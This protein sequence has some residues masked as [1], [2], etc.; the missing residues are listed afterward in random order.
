MAASGA[1]DHRE[2]LEKLRDRLALVIETASDRDLAPLAA[3]YQSVL[4]DLASLPDPNAA[5]DSVESAQDDVADV[6]RLVQ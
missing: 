6:L 3:R 2:R 1:E 4:S 5:A